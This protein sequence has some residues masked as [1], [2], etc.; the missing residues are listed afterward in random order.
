MI[1]KEI[2]GQLNRIAD[3][4]EAQNEILRKR[5]EG[6]DRLMEKFNG[7]ADLVLQFMPTGSGVP[8][9]GRAS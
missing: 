9:G 1:E 2:E 4:L 7:F 6:F 3:A 8:G 5:D